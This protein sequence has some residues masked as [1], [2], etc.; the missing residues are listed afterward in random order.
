[1]NSN[2][3]ENLVKAGIVI[4]GGIL[5]YMALKPSKDKI[6]YTT[7]NNATPPPPPK[8]ANGEATPK[9]TL[10]NAEIVADA[11]TQALKAAETPSKLTELNQECMKEFGM[12]CYVDK[13]GKLVV[14]DVSG[15]TILTK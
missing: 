7:N 15:N 3:K 1:M 14:C 8:N 11:Y 2:I 4:G 10:E 13:E 5:L 12:R 9:P 6:T